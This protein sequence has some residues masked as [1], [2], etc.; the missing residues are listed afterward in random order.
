MQVWQAL[1][2]G[3]SIKRGRKWKEAQTYANVRH[4]VVIETS[5]L[6]SGTAPF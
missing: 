2:G 6:R 1:G 4:V 5:V 3:E